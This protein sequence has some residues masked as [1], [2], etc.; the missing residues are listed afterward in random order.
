MRSVTAIPKS[1]EEKLALKSHIFGTYITLRFGMG[2]L[3]AALP[4]VLYVV[5]KFHGIN[6][7]GS[8]SAY[9][10]AGADGVIAPRGVFV[11]GL[12][13][14]GAFLYLYK[15]FTISENIAL[16]FA[17]IFAA[18]VAFFPMSWNC[19]TGL[20]RLPPVDVRHCPSIFNPHGASAI[21]LFACLA[22]VSL[23][24][25]H[26][27]LPALNNPALELQY[28]M[29]Y[30]VTGALMLASPII[31]AVLRVEFNRLDSYTYFVELAGIVAFA[32]FWIVKSKEMS[33]TRLVEKAL[34][35]QEERAV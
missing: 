10:W 15:G 8:M 21:A 34:E 20:P 30:R 7:Q 29:I 26:D 27:T 5:G 17:A 11:G 19:E 23:F 16:N 25:S 2:V 18:I 35:H 3:A 24:R 9:Y 6:L 33:Q 22:Y 12:L 13:A 28:K 1:N 31:A 4:L 32:S 14:I